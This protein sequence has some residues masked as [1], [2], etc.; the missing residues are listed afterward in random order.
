MLK[1]LSIYIKRVIS[2]K[3]RH[4][5]RLY[6]VVLVTGPSELFERG[7]EQPRFSDY[8]NNSLTTGQNFELTK[9]VK[10]LIFRGGFPD[11]AIP[12]KSPLEGDVAVR[13]RNYIDTYLTKDL[14]QLQLVKDIGAF[15]KFLRRFALYSSLIKGPSDIAS[16]IGLPR[17]TIHNWYSLLRASYLSTEIPAFAKP[18]GKRE[19][20]NSKFYILDSGLMANLMGYQNSDQTFQSPVLGQ[21]FETYAF[22]NFRSWV[23]LSIQSPMFYHWRYD[24]E[25]EVDLIFENTP[26]DLIAVEFKMTSKPQKSDLKGIREFQKHYPACKRAIIV[27]CFEKLVYIDDNV[28]NIPITML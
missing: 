27:S 24:E 15:E 14:R 10:E 1:F 12:D 11:M 21:L 19:R 20:K 22:Q 17:S 28:L 23:S 4:L 9:P 16:D 13:M 2:E 8:C 7:Q 25:F 3:L 6:P 26:S 18:L 5:S